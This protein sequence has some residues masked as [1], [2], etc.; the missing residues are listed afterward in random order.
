M[1]DHVQSSST[2][3]YAI[4]GATNTVIPRLYLELKESVSELRVIKG[5]L[6]SRV[7]DRTIQRFETESPSQLKLIAEQWS[8]NGKLPV[9]DY[10]L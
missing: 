4:I 5:K 8:M 7:K 1:T 2:T 10:P 6:V 9:K 3:R